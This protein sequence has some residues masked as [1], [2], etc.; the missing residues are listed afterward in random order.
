M[1]LQS[2]IWISIMNKILLFLL[3]LL[4]TL[5]EKSLSESITININANVMERSCTILNDSLNSTVDL[6]SRDLRQGNTEVG[7]PFAGTPFS[8]SLIDCPSN[9]STA[10]IK[11]SGESDSTMDHLLKNRLNEADVAAQAIAL[12]LY[13]ADMKN[14]D[15]K[16]NNEILN[17]D[18]GLA[19]NSF[20]FYVYYVKTSDSPQAGKI[21]SVADFEVTYD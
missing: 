10:H 15:I 8:I 3:G 12:G 6:Q 5:P 20:N 21:I 9:I 14:I 19:T 4:I 17:I 16:N 1:R 2:L 18:H 13:D 11:F 7:V